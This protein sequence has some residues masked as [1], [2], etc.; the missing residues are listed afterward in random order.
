MAVSDESAS[1]MQPSVAAAGASSLPTD[2]STLLLLLLLDTL[3][4]DDNIEGSNCASD[5]NGDVCN[6]F[7]RL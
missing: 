4:F 5:G 1:R 3:L 2:G 6:S 7:E